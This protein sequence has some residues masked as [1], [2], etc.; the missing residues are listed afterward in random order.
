MA[1][2]KVKLEYISDATARRTTYKKRKKGMIKKVNELS[3]LCG[4]PACAIISSPFD[5]KAEIWPDP[6]GAKEVIQKYQDASVLDQSKN[7]NQESY[8]MQKI[9]KVQD[10]LKKLRQENHDKENTLS[11]CNYVQGEHLPNDVQELLQLNNLIHKTIREIQI[12]SDVLNYD[13][14]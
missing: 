4:I 10:Q 5:S 14:T 13:S 9:V 1:R 11:I 7:V 3:I 6:D 8:I 2:K 12:L